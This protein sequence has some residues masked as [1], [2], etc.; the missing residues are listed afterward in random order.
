M[1]SRFL[2]L[3]YILYINIQEVIK[4]YSGIFVSLNNINIEIALK[5]FSRLSS[6]REK[7]QEEEERRRKKKK[8]EETRSID[9]SFVGKERKERKQYLSEWD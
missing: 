1:I 5:Y 9:R 2:F 6:W 4:Y 3:S 7:I 8:E